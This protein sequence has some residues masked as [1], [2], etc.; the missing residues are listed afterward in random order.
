MMNG[1]ATTPVLPY[2][3]LGDGLRATFRVVYL[4]FTVPIFGGNILV[5]LSTV[6]Y[7]QLR[8]GRHL[9]LVSLSFAD[10][11][12]GLSIVMCFFG[13]NPDVYLTRKP[14]C[15]CCV[16]FVTLGPSISLYS[17]LLVSVERYVKIV[18]TAR[19]HI[20]FSRN[21]IALWIGFTWIYCVAL[22][23]V[24]LF[25]NRFWGASYCSLES[26]APRLFLY[27]VIYAQLGL[28]LVINATLYALILREVVRQGKQVQDLSVRNKSKQTER[29]AHVVVLIVLGI[30]YVCWGPYFVMSF[31]PASSA[32]GY[33]VMYYTA[34]AT[35]YVSSFLN[36]FIYAW[37][38]R[39]FRTAFYEILTCRRCSS[40]AEPEST[41]QC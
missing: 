21:K 24:I 3:D 14:T 10:I 34:L 35:I 29:K 4:V 28:L 7:P 11:A 19:Y 9:C 30:L 37:K 20:F 31:V 32:L 27:I 39:E 1:T 33:N 38:N 18:H 6:L 40:R 41:T 36:P 15:L 26:I 12:V 13:S 5:I 2:A 16:L 25:K 8:K 22:I 23:S 17:V